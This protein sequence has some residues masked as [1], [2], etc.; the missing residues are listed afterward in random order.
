MDL[1]CRSIRG[2]WQWKQR[3][4]DIYSTAKSLKFQFVGVRI[5]TFLASRPAP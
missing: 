3:Q 5:V 4:D 2:C 1:L